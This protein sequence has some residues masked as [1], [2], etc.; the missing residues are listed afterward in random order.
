MMGRKCDSEAKDRTSKKKDFYEF[1]YD[2]E[3][4]TKDTLELEPF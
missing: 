1:D 3:H 4:T 2:K